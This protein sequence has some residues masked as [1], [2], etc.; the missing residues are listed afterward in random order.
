MTVPVQTDRVER[1]PQMR[2]EKPGLME[3]Y[4]VR[5]LRTA[6]CEDGASVDGLSVLSFFSNKKTMITVNV[7]KGV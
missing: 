7:A 4:C 5:P 3:T 2:T 6:V 1:A